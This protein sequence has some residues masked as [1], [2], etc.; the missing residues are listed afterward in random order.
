VSL[1]AACT[2][3]WSGWLLIWNSIS[4]SACIWD[5]QGIWRTIKYWFFSNVPNS[6]KGKQ[7]NENHMKGSPCDIKS[8]A[9][10]FPPIFCLLPLSQAILR[11]F[12][13]WCSLKNINFFQE[14]IF[15]LHSQFWC[16]HF[17]KFLRYDCLYFKS[18]SDRRFGGKL[19]HLLSIDQ[20][21][22][23]LLVQ[24]RYHK[25]IFGYSTPIFCCSI[26]LHTHWLL[27][28]NNAFFYVNVHPSLTEKLLLSKC[29]FCCLF[30]HSLNLDTKFDH[31]SQF[32]YAETSLKHSLPRI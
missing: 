2:W 16:V 21:Q 25:S 14:K 8:S 9:I 20:F 30:T 10:F 31:Q 27:H 24:E 29:F 13:N 18:N 19:T 28:S 26:T 15:F 1:T 3:L 5:F 32:W 17:V 6:N 23:F 7:K 12:E 4:S 11:S 22:N